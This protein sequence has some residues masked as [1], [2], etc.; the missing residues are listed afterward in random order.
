M[1]NAKLYSALDRESEQLAAANEKLKTLDKMKDEF[2]SIAAHELRTPM[3]IIKSYIWMVAQG[4]GGEI[5]EKQK[6]YLSRATT[7]VE[8]MLHLVNDMLDVSRIEQ[9]RVEFKLQPVDIAGLIRE[10]VDDFK[11]KTDEKGLWL[12]VDMPD[13]VACVTA[14][15]EKLREVLTNFAGNS[16]KFTDKG[17][18]TIKV[19]VIE[20]NRIKTSIID[21]GP[22][23]G[24]EDMSTLF[25]KF[26][27]V[28]N[29]LTKQAETPGT[30]LGLYISKNYVEK[31]GGNVGVSS[32]GLGKGTTFWFTLPIAATETH[33]TS[34][35]H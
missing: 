28:N 20:N 13:L 21:T 32:E 18:L 27:R 23:I 4:K 11:V 35:V 26:Q 19:Q 12:N 31:M 9:G 2:L 6:G 22:G 10:F 29:T 24:K 5:N 7:G 30:G 17:G 15:L 33:V 25:Q 34:L 1:Q 16:L 3:T 14:D 8:R